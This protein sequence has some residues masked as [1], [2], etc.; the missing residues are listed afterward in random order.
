MIM[1]DKF[2]RMRKEAVVMLSV[3]SQDFCGGNEENS[4][5]DLP[6]SPIQFLIPEGPDF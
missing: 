5:Q 1:N 2:L 6:R 4:S 3:L